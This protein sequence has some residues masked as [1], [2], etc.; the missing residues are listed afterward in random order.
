MP[1]CGYGEGSTGYRLAVAIGTLIIGVLLLVDK[2]DILKDDATKNITLFVFAI[3][4]FSFTISDITALANASMA[5][6]VFIKEY[7]PDD[8][9]F[10]YSCHPEQYGM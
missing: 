2:L 6:E 7:S 5:C 9:T 4:W 1:Y 8:D 3:F 10:T